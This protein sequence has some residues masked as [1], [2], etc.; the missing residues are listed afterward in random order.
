MTP[1]AAPWLTFAIRIWRRAE[2][3]DVFGRAAQLSY[4]LLLAVFP[5]LLFIT[6]LFGLMAETGTALRDALFTRLQQVMPPSALD[7]VDGTLREISAG[8]GGGK[9][10][11]G[12]LGTVWAAARGMRAIQSALNV[13]YGVRET[14]GWW[15]ARVTSV[16]L[17]V[18]IP[19]FMIT[20]MVL[21]LYGSRIARALATHL[22]FS[23]LFTFAWELLQWPLAA[24]FVVAAFNLVDHFAPARKRRWRWVTSGATAGAALW[25]VASVGLRIYLSYFDTYSATYGS[26]G[27]VI[28]LMVWLY[29]TG[30]A[31]LVVGEVNAE[32]ESTSSQAALIPHG[33]RPGAA[34]SGT[35]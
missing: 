14:R 33:D 28:V 13:A 35:G 12:V 32:L 17:T 10:S 3:H 24:F 26:L 16:L 22:G 5:A 1:R 18:A 27:A 4:Y 11:L 30:I 25:L 6:A 7:L 2:A 8:A 15:R 31:I 20:G 23:S 19:V 9:L 29:L 34:A 21:A